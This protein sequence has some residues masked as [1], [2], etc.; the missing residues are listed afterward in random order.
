MRLGRWFRRYR[1]WIAIGALALAGLAAFLIVRG[2]G[3]PEGGPTYTT[4]AARSGTLSVTVAGTGNVEVRDLVEVWPTV[5]GMVERVS[6]E[7][8]DRVEEGDA[9]FCLEHD[10]AEVNLAKA[11]ASLRQ[12]Q[13]GVEQ[14]ES[15]L[16]KAENTLE[17]LEDR[18]ASPTSTVTDGQVRA[19]EQDVTAARAGL[20]SARSSRSSAWRAYAKAQEDEAELNLK[21]PCDG[22]VWSVS[23]ERGASVSSKGGGGSD[24]GQ[25]AS[26]SGAP[27]VIAR[28]GE[29]AVRLAVNEVDVPSL[30]VGQRAELAFDAV[31]DLRI[32]GRVDEVER[33]GTVE[34]GVVSYDVWIS[35]DVADKRLRTAMSSSATIVTSVARGVLLVPNAAVKSGTEGTYVQVLDP[36]ASAPRDVYV[37]TGLKGA[38]QTVI[39][40]GLKAGALVVTKTTQAGE[41]GASGSSGRS[42]GG[43]FMPG[44]GRPP[45][46][47]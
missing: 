8:G 30:K 4:E 26:S 17:E 5:G 35:L 3:K 16:I 31:P 38:S 29:L 22:V 6:V 43:F 15:Q 14:A 9:L 25:T 11:L 2:S 47:R 41:D 7:E 23:V 19:A 42:G 12:A 18:S 33:D 20:R 13:Q 36:G 1:V 44:M 24:S 45:G 39:V 28:D 40:R 37:T 21:A 34:Q 46:N 32:T 10:E 27:V